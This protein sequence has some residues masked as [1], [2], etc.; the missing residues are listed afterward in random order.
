MKT[1]KTLLMLLAITLFITSCKNEKCYECEKYEYCFYVNPNCSGM[2]PATVC[3]DTEA[4]RDQAIVTT[5]NTLTQAGCTGTFTSS[6]NLKAGF[7]QEICDKKDEADDA[8][9]DLEIQ[10]YKCAEE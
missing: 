7:Q 9:N 3:F 8:A 6:E 1:T 2:S 4:E 5:Q 10:G